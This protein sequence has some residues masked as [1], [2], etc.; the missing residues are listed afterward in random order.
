[1]V[2]VSLVLSIPPERGT[3]TVRGPG[4]TLGPHTPTGASSMLRSRSLTRTLRRGWVHASR[5][6]LPG[7]RL[8]RLT[9]RPVRR[10]LRLGLALFLVR[11]DHHDHVPA[12]L[13]WTRLDVTELIDVLGEPG[14]QP[15]AELRP[16]LLTAAEHDGDFDLVTLPEEPHYVTLLGLVV[17]RVDLWPEFDLLDDRV[18]LVLPRLA[19]LHRRLVFELA[20]VHEPSDGRPRGGRD[21]D[22]V[23][24]R[25]AGDFE[26][27]GDGHDAHLLAVRTD[28]PDLGHANAI[29][30]T[31]FGADGT[32]LGPDESVTGRTPGPSMR[33]PRTTCLR[34][35]LRS[36]DVGDAR[37]RA[38]HLTRNRAPEPRPTGP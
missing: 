7:T 20:V 2:A 38:R 16:G 32:S 18:R 34:G 9:P 37:Y 28:E 30:D 19:G 10:T 5:M 1:M 4:P 31:R 24:I 22:Q 23:E 17:M 3:P 25:L 26:G 27:L 8:V 33:K 29:V 36:P 21:L 12:V 13:L 14:Q 15:A 6:P 35:H 11:T